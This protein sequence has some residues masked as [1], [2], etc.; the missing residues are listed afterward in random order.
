MATSTA[1]ATSTTAPAA[2][3]RSSRG[4][5]EVTTTAT[6]VAP[7]SASPIVRFAVVSAAAIWKITR[8]RVTPRIAPKRY[9]G[10]PPFG[11]SALPVPRY[12]PGPDQ[13]GARHRCRR[14]LPL[15]SRGV[16]LAHRL[17]GEL[18]A[19]GVHYLGDL[20]VRGEQL[21]ANHRR[22]VLEREQPPRVAQERVT[23]ADE[24]AV[25]GEDG[26]QADLPLVER[27]VLVADRERR[28]VHVAQ[29][30]DVAQPD[31]PLEARAEL[32]WRA[33]RR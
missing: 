32:G 2:I 18:G 16:H 9:L 33:D 30:V 7:C 26:G 14:H 19:H 11:R 20:G 28:H 3:R 17:G 5:P 13:E 23:P 15:H 22:D 31:E 27:G 1:M 21:G 24:L 25:G 8:P 6:S 29:A 12:Q 10:G 4:A